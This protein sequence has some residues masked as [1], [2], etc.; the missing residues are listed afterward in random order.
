M[1]KEP[2]SLQDAI[3]YFSNQ[4]NC[5]EYL[6]SRRWPD[7]VICPICGAKKVSEFNSKRRTWK[8]GSHHPRRE[9]SVKVGTIFEESAISLDKWL[10]A[11]WQVVN[12]K[13]GISSY[14]LAKNLDL[15]QK[16]G[17][18]LLH[19]IRLALKS[20]HGIYTMG[21][22]WSN[23]IEVDETF[24]GGTL[25]NMHRKR[26]QAIR[27]Q[28]PIDRMEGFETSLNKKTVVMGMFNRQTREVRAKVIPNVKRE[29]LQAEILKNIGFN[30]HVFTDEHIGYD[31]LDKLKNF[32]HRTVN[33]TNEYVN[34]RVHTNSI[35]N[36]WSLLK[37]GLV[38]TYV[39]VEPFHLDAYVDE[40]VFRFNNRSRKGRPMSDFD[41]FN[42]AV[43]QIAGKRVT[44]D[45]LT[46]KAPN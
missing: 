39:A 45:Q 21:S 17:W 35:E 16:S 33:H 24:V 27:A 8:C 42:L 40:Q 28:V 5:I 30:A 32:T 38:G 9:F 18:F 20:E 36:F 2:K 15:T 43:G 23:P 22:N 6:S 37:R 12:C 14:E 46:G 31:G 13:N 7:G 4:D 29:T 3:I 26:A 10:T 44:F 34:G 11:I 41:R 19:R 25:K 1:V